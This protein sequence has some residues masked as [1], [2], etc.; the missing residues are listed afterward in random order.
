M[1]RALLAISALALCGSPARAADPDPRSRP[2]VFG[3]PVPHGPVV[4]K[5]FLGLHTGRTNLFFGQPMRIEAFTVDPAVN[6]PHLGL[7]NDPPFELTDAAGKRVPFRLER[8]GS[9]SG[10]G[11]GFAQFTLW[12]TKAHAAGAYWKPGT[13]KLNLTLVIPDEQPPAR[14]AVTGTFRANELAFTVREPGAAR[15]KWDGPDKLRA[16]DPLGPWASADVFLFAA[17]LDDES[18]ARLLK[19]GVTSGFGGGSL[20]GPAWR[21]GLASYGPV[22]VPQDRKLTEAEAKQLIADLDSKDP[23]TRVRAVRAVPPTA[24]AEVIAAAAELLL[25]GYEETVGGFP[26]SPIY[27]IT[28]VAQEALARLGAGAVPALI[29]FAEQKGRKVTAFQ[30]QPRR[31]AAHVLGGIGPTDASETYLRAALRSDDDDRVQNAVFVATAWGT[32]GAGLVREALAR[33]KASVGARRAAIDALGRF[34]TLADDGPALRKLLAAPEREVQAAA[35]GALLALRDTESVPALDRI[36]RDPKADV[37]AR[38]SA[39]HTVLS[40]S[41]AK[42][43]TRFILDL[44]DLNDE[45]DVHLR[46]YGME[47]AGR[48]K[49]KAAVKPVLAA[50]DDAE[51]LTR[52]VADRALRELADRPDGVGFD[53]KKPDALLWRVLWEKK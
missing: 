17:G 12:P 6:G 45:A 38:L 8:H 14:R 27:P 10:N 43:G 24:P 32:R 1:R 15:E 19:R 3:R 34:G 50:L 4:N 48:R 37:G 28:Y 30:E 16:L 9:G 35:V 7:P 49:L 51:E 13:Y 39:A 22:A 11:G 44:I 47:Q 26:P 20:G 18:A 52:I 31:A 33:P 40:L 2:G 21:V 42:A 46:Y 53:P 25:D 41:D 29:A 23:A 5:A 36:A